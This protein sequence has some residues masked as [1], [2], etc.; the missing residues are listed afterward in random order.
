MSRSDLGVMMT[1]G[2]GSGCIALRERESSIVKEMK[3][4]K[5]NTTLN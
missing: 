5:V 3:L 1:P 4:Y 2:S